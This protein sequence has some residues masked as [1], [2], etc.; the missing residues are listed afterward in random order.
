MKC[1]HARA[2]SIFINSRASPPAPRPPFQR[3]DARDHPCGSEISGKPTVEPSDYGA[4]RV[5]AQGADVSKSNGS[6]QPDHDQDG[7]SK[8][9]TDEP[10][11]R[12]IGASEL[13]VGDSDGLQVRSSLKHLRVCT[14]TERSDLAS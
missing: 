5:S 11:Q 13:S 12:L 1:G 7:I 3:R 9:Q 4:W 6:D 14:N 10:A 8:Y 2:R